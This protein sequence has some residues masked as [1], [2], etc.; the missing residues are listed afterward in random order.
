ML[1]KFN[2][3]HDMLLKYEE[4]ALEAYAENKYRFSKEYIMKKIN[5]AKLTPGHKKLLADFLDFAHKD[6]DIIKF[7]W[8]YY[9]FQFE[10]SECFLDNMWEGGLD[11]VP[12]PDL[13]EKK[14]PGALK[15]VVYLAASD[16]LKEYLGRK[17]ISGSHIEDYY[18]N[19]KRFAD[20][21]IVTHNTY[22]L[23]RLAPFVYAYAYPFI[24]NAGRFR[25]QITHFKDYCEVYEDKDGKRII[26]ATPIYSYDKK[27]LRDENSSFF[28]V[29]EIKNGILKAHTF[30]SIGRL[31]ESPIE[32][33]LSRNKK[34][35]SKEDLVATIHIPAGGRLSDETV[36]SSL[37]EAREAM[38]KIFTDYDI[39]AIVCQTW[40]LD[41][42]LREILPPESNMIKFQKR[43]DLVMAADNKNHSLFDHIFNVKPTSLEKLVPKNNFQ[44][45]MFKRALKGEKIYWGFGILKEKEAHYDKGTN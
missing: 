37:A 7:M 32:I 9:F 20:L 40:F 35:L 28:P 1:E 34:I 16:H 38:P 13:C 45:I 5:E 24:I 12:V 8:L 21:N 33:D 26:V 23:C 27:G 43:F 41:T 2:L 14:F 10:T 19:Y 6:D 31:C 18:D 25:F 36:D 42:Q 3:K 39:R 15:S 30:D 4:T 29:Y 22:G 11:D 17:N 44:E